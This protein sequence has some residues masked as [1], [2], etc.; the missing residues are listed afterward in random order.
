MC[1]IRFF[2]KILLFSVVFT[3]IH[4]L[5]NCSRILLA[6]YRNLVIIHW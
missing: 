5:V 4:L 3:M 2:F 6:V 1:K